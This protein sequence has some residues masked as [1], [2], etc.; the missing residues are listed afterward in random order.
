MKHKK[1]LKLHVLKK[2]LTKNYEDTNYNLIIAQN[3]NI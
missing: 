1:K 3:R 2:S